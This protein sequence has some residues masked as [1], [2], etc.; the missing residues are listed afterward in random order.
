MSNREEQT[1]PQQS[2]DATGMR[3]LQC[4][5]PPP[6]GMDRVFVITYVHNHGHES[7][8]I[9]RLANP[10]RDVGVQT[11][12]ITPPPR[13]SAATNQPPP[14]PQF[15]VAT[16][17]PTPPPQFSAAT[18]QPP[19]PPQFFVATNQPP[20]PPQLSREQIVAGRGRGYISPRLQQRLGPAPEQRP[21]PSQC[22]Q[23]QRPNPNRPRPIL[24]AVRSVWCDAPHTIM[25]CDE[26]LRLTPSQRRVAQRRRGR[27]PNCLSTHSLPF[28]NSPKRCAAPKC[29]KKHNTLLHE[30]PGGI[31]ARCVTTED[32]LCSFFLC[33]ASLVTLTICFPLS[34]SL[35][36]ISL[37]TRDSTLTSEQFCF[38]FY[39]QYLAVELNSQSVSAVD[40]M[41]TET[42]N[43][44][45][46]PVGR[47][48]RTRL[49]F[50]GFSCRARRSGN[51]LDASLARVVRHVR[52]RSG[53]PRLLIAVPFTPYLKY[54][55]LLSGSSHNY[56]AAKS[57]RNRFLKLRRVSSSS[58][59]ML[60]RAD[61]ARAKK[62]LGAALAE[63]R[64]TLI[65]RQLPRQ[66]GE[67]TSSNTHN[68]AET[69]ALIAEDVTDLESDAE[70]LD[71][72]IKCVPSGQ[73]SELSQTENS[74][75]QN[76]SATPDNI[77][78]V[79]KKARM[80][81]KEDPTIGILIFLLVLDIS[82]KQPKICVFKLYQ[83][84]PQCSVNVGCRAATS[85]MIVKI[86]AIEHRGGLGRAIS[87]VESRNVIERGRE[88]RAGRARNAEPIGTVLL[89]LEGPVNGATLVTVYRQKAIYIYPDED[90]TIEVDDEP[91]L[92]E[93][94]RFDDLELS[95]ED[96]LDWLHSPDVPEEIPL[97][98]DL[99]IAA[100]IDIPDI[101][102]S[103][104]PGDYFN[105]PDPVELT[106]DVKINA[107]NGA[108]ANINITGNSQNGATDITTNDI[109]IQL[110][111]GINRDESFIL[112][113]DHENV[114]SS[115]I[116]C[117]INAGSKLTNKLKIKF[118]NA[119]GGEE[120]G[121]DISGLTLEF[122]QLA[123]TDLQQSMLFYGTDKKLLN[124]DSHA[125]KEKHFFCGGV[126]VAL[127][128]IHGGPC[129]DFFAEFLL[130]SIF[131]GSAQ[132]K[133]EDLKFPLV[134][135]DIEELR[136]AKTIDEAETVLKHSE[137]LDIAGCR[138][139][140]HELEEVRLMK[141]DDFRSVIENPKLFLIL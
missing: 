126:I 130:D 82:Q 53:I 141:C 23:D 91:L 79:S 85:S 99:D 50:R 5:P 37:A 28:C 74:Q 10:V 64:A 30:G 90:L 136:C 21:G 22:H 129:P 66:A 127:S 32:I 139:R 119:A 12:M 20:P 78:P 65:N 111:R 17:L 25:Q 62:N 89:E 105:I 106:E 24:G 131:T 86:A 122:C 108:S 92:S 3:V 13:F 15:F 45:T 114:F 101:D 67:G 9:Y 102:A 4:A 132:P 83:A 19:P 54:L 104:N 98:N 123:I 52:F 27:C 44:N 33:I 70:T 40:L 34:L 80:E 76:P 43:N 96:P 36:F 107:P 8:T 81:R 113:I 115:S 55:T 94:D 103:T 56:V 128:L 68:A 57:T 124:N 47:R 140:I 35:I 1:G 51:L 29:G 95:P 93:D 138:K 6:P 135:K 88:S 100:E 38:L 73:N 112:N 42:D 134:A 71:K 46:I 116:P 97:L 87:Q 2:L 137:V 69:A 118:N 48:G 133:M 72:S 61:K 59:F 18:N 77:Q 26:L 31:P 110:A 117:I 120:M 121:I 60:D 14:P 84:M 7:R 125:V 63:S 75:N 58:Y 16:N 39:A 49:R 11:E 109:L 41:S